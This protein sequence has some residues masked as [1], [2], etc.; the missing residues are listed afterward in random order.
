V[1][2]LIVI[3]PILALAGVASAQEQVKPALPS[4]VQIVPGLKAPAPNK[5]YLLAMPTQEARAVILQ[6]S[7]PDAACSVPLLRAEIPKDV[8]Y[9]ISE[10]RPRPE[11]LA[12]M[13]HASLPAQPCDS[14]PARGWLSVPLLRERP[15]KPR[16]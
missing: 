9:T 10:V 2:N 5:P 6:Q 16:P 15:A 8:D 4:H 1:R 7:L 3:L 11:D 13:P 12:P 14:G